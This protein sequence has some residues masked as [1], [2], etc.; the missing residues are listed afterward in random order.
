MNKKSTLLKSSLLLTLTISS[1]G[2][3]LFNSLRA[4]AQNFCTIS[5]SDLFLSR[6]PSVDLERKIAIA[7]QSIELVGKV[8]KIV[9]AEGVQTY[10][11]ERDSSFVSFGPSADLYAVKKEGS[12]ITPLSKRVGSHYKVGDLPAWEFDKSRLIAKKVALIKGAEGD[13][14]PWLAVETDKD[15]YYILRLETRGGLPP[16]ENCQFKGILGIPY[17]TFYVIVKTGNSQVR[18]RID[19]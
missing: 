8:E 11:M 1:L 16:E 12:I 14:I 17:Q 13:D 6:F 15:G 2:C 18:N 3:Q 10:R 4:N 5:Q 7:M 9:W 19:F